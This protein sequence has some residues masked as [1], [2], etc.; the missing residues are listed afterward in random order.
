MNTN[1]HA[2]VQNL[3]KHAA[4]HVDGRQNQKDT[5]ETVL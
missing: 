1:R 2:N 4:K 3:D 5:V